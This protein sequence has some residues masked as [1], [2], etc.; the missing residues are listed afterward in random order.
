VAQCAENGK[1]DSFSISEDFMRMTFDIVG[2]TG[3]LTPQ[4]VSRL[5]LKARV[6]FAG[7]GHDFKSLEGEP[8]GEFTRLLKRNLGLRVCLDTSPILFH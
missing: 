6:P 4:I 8:D 7:F 3:M 1:S 5:P 2:E